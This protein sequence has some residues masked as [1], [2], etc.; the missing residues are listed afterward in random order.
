MGSEF[1]TQPLADLVDPDRGITY[2]IV[3][4]GQ[5]VD[6][7]VP[8]IRVTDIRN[9]RVDSSAPLRVASEI[10]AKYKRTRLRGGELLLTLVGTVGETAVVPANLAGWN[11]A[12]AVAVIPV[13]AEIGARWVQYALQTTLIRDYIHSRL[14][15]TV[16]VTLNIGDVNRVSIPLPNESIRAAII[17]VLGTLDD[18]IELNR[19]MN[20][21]LEG[22]ARALFKSWFVDF[23]PV[24]AKMEGRDTGLPEDLAALFPS[25]LVPSVL[26]D[27]PEGWGVTALADNIDLLS[28]GTPSTAEPSYWG[29]E[30]PWFSVKDTPTDSDVWVISTE[31]TITKLGLDKSATQVLP[32]GTTIVT[33]RGTVGKLALVGTPMAMNQSCYGVRGKFGYSNSFIYYLLR[34]ATAELRQRT[35]GTVFDTITR[36][37][38]AGLNFAFP[39][40]I[41]T[42]EFHILATPQLEK[43]LANLHHSRTLSTLRDTLLP[44]LLSG[45]VRVEG[46]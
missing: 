19:Q 42:Q 12:R 23:E 21:T 10:E 32:A 39:A 25:R 16:Q 17:D 45:E 2:G 18:R 44:K 14:N 5:P 11:T 29:G 30:I 28:G 41:L 24:R 38:F 13:K 35:H 7:G 1:G 33:A 8:I 20:E 43:I 46:V 3:Q 9:G 6:D 22:L 15:T 40:P 36:Q 34:F 4:P 31:K 27:I 37:T 26:G